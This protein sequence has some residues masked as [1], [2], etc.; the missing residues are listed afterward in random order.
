MKGTATL[1][2]AGN[3]ASNKFDGANRL[4]TTIGVADGDRGDQ[5]LIFEG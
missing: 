3:V 5:T 1:R 2:V 4:P